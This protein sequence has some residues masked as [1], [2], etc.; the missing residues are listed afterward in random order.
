[1]R[2][3]VALASAAASATLCAAVGPAVAGPYSDTLARCLVRST[4]SEDKSS[5]VQ[6]MF[7]TAALHPDVR[8]LS[9]AT[10]SDRVTLNKRVAKLFETLLT[11]SCL[12]EA[13]EVLKYEGRSTME[14]SFTV[15]GKV[16]TRE[17]FS[18]S[19]VAAGM[20]ELDKN[21]DEKKFQSALGPF[22]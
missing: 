9:S 4:T 22:K 7:V 21:F 3:R 1:M 11:E 18:H 14:T 13:K 8:R 15:L 12:A 19:A 17:L 10:A 2:I 5:L 6:W 16:A 20:A